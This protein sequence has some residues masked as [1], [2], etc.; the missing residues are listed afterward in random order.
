MLDYSIPTNY[1]VKNQVPGFVRQN[2]E[3]FVQFLEAYYEYLDQDQN[4]ND[5][6]RNVISYLDP[7]KTTEYLLLNFFDEL[8]NFPKTFEVDKRF[9]AKHIYDLF[10][11][12]GTESSIETL[13]RILFDEKVSVVYPKNNI[14]IASDGRWVQDVFITVQGVIN[15]LPVGKNLDINLIIRNSFGDFTIAAKTIE[16][17]DDLYRIYFSGTTPVKL[18]S[19]T[20][21]LRLDSA[22]SK[23]FSGILKK[24][25]SVLEVVD[26]GKF[27]TIGSIVTI[28]GTIDN[29][30]CRV[31]NTST[32]GNGSL[33][34]LQII[35]YGYGHSEDQ[36][37]VTSPY[38]NKP[39]GSN[40]DISYQDNSYTI[41]ITDYVD[42]SMEVNG[43]T[44]GPTPDSYYSEIYTNEVYTGSPILST[45]YTTGGTES[46]VPSD[47]SI[48]DWLDSKTI[49]RYKYDLIGRPTGDWAGDHGKVSNSSIRIQD[50][51]Y[52]QLY[53]YAIKNTKCI[54][55]W[56]K[57]IELIHPAGLKYFGEFIK[58]TDVDVSS[59]QA[60]TTI[61]IS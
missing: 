40:I 16:L 59:H 13:F 60:Q 27:W 2:H 46:N 20:Y 58:S 34:R 61:T 48:K 55:R 56:K 32:D 1:V 7:D 3:K 10:H 31:I 23:L 14:L 50:N 53:S 12:K 49:L 38:P 22:G 43:I 8:K 19:D 17:V 47:L 28:K 11:A 39:L 44:S 4:I 35:K 21:V 30:I 15:S 24:S 52:Y 33:V 37:I 5:Y 57:V 51:Y 25:P 6:I 54:N 45:S 41:D 26:P 18:N 36:I 42:Y 9:I 29:T